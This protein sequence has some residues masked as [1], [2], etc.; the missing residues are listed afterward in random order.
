MVSDLSDCLPVSSDAALPVRGP[1]F[2]TV[3]P[4]LSD[5]SLP[6]QWERKVSVTAGYPVG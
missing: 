2:Q 6:S 4:C 5:L 3:V 1:G